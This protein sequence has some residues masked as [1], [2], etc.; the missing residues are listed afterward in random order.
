MSITLWILA[1]LAAAIAIAWILID[2]YVEV[3][4]DHWSYNL[5]GEGRPEILPKRDAEHG[6]PLD[7]ALPKRGGQP[8]RREGGSD[9][10]GERIRYGF[11]S[12]GQDD[13]DLTR[14]VTGLAVAFDL[15]DAPVTHHAE[16]DGHTGSSDDCSSHH[17][18]AGHDSSSHHSSE[19]G[20]GDHGSNHG[21]DW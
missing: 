11:R 6:A 21:S 10:Q 16:R 8:A 17:S 13:L 20:G 2:D 14:T 15:L 4:H 12:Q 5:Q 18:S 3:E 19:C 1:G 9:D 7:R